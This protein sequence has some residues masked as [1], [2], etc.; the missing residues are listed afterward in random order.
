MQNI[1]GLLCGGVLVG[2]LW[3]IAR[4]V[5]QDCD[6]RTDVER[7]VSGGVT[8]RREVSLFLPNSDDPHQ[9]GINPCN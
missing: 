6:V 8:T 1:H 7:S 9:R 2:R 5:I 4:L 3:H